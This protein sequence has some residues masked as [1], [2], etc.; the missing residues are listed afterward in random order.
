MKDKKQTT[1]FYT[2]CDF[3]YVKKLEREA[4]KY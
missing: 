3:N 4:L 1:K 2:Y